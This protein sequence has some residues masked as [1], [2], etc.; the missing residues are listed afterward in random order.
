LV[1]LSD[2]EIKKTRRS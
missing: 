2:Q 1:D